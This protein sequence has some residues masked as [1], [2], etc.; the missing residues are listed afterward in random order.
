MSTKGKPWPVLCIGI[1]F[2]MMKHVAEENLDLQKWNEW[3]SGHNFAA[4]CLC[5]FGN[6]MRQLVKYWV[7]SCLRYRN[8]HST[9]WPAARHA[10]TV[11]WMPPGSRSA[12]EKNLDLQ[13]MENPE[14]EN[15]RLS[16]NT[17]Q[18]LKNTL[19]GEH[20][21]IF[22]DKLNRTQSNNWAL[23]VYGQ[24]KNKNRIFVW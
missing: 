15:K 18:G 16:V 3:C 13:K 21:L 19:L 17:Q 23:H 4:V 6:N 9:S 10:T 14:S 20:N 8:D 22:S 11:L 24:P 2:W 7:E 1:T 5:W 12:A